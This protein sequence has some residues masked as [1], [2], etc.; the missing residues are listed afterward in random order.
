MGYSRKKQTGIED[1]LFW[2]PPWNFRICYFTLRNS[3]EN[4][5]LSLEILQNCDTPW[6]FQGQ[7]PRPME[8]PHDF[9]LNTTGNSSS[10]FIDPWN[11]HML[12][13]QYPL[14]RAGK[15]GGASQGD[16]GPPTFFQSKKKI[17]NS[18]RNKLKDT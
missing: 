11:F 12:F 1:I 4:K 14:D 15:T 8:I 6:K 17:N 18:N 10:F 3:G 7:K 9:F 16:H 5:F 2:K 13:L